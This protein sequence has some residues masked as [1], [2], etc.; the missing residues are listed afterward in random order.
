[1]QQNQ[2]LSNDKLKIIAAAAM[3]IDHIGAYLLPTVTVLRIIGRISF[4]IFAFM[5]AEGCAYTGNKKKYL[6][7]MFLLAVFCQIAFYPFKPPGYMRIPVTFLISM[8]VVFAL[9]NCMSRLYGNYN[10]IT[11]FVSVTALLLLILATAY[12]NRI[13]VIDYG[14]YG[15]MTPAIVSAVYPHKG[16]S[17][18]DRKY[19]TLYRKIGM[20]TIALIFV[21]KEYGGVQIYSFFAIPLLAMYNG[22][23]ENIVPKY[24][25]YIF[26][27]AHLAV[28][29]AIKYLIK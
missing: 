17:A 23:R 29:Y 27:P 10:N 8:T 7:N 14:F 4:P 2:S 6:L 19:D 25:F 18:K 16:I 13:F 22:K 5:I 3:L 26:Y 21:Y 9:Q 12:L 11:K 24:F 20:L 28:I 1:M 15:C